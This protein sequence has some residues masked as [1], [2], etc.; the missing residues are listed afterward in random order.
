MLWISQEEYSPTHEHHLP[1]ELSESKWLAVS[2]LQTGRHGSRGRGKL[3]WN[4]SGGELTWFSIHLE[5]LKKI[6]LQ[7]F[8]ALFLLILKCQWGFIK[9]VFWS[10]GMLKKKVWPFFPVP[11][12]TTGGRPRYSDQVGLQPGSVDAPLSSQILLQTAGWEG[13]QQNSLP[14]PELQVNEGQRSCV[15]PMLLCFANAQLEICLLV[16]N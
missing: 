8:H 4:G 11:G 1:E 3:P 15:H 10:F 6:I 7:H 2:H 13:E 14:R 5:P 9:S 12:T 16:F